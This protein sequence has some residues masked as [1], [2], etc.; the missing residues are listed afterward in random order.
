[1][2]A[3]ALPRFVAPTRGLMPHAA[4]LLLGAGSSDFFSHL[5]SLGEGSGGGSSS[6]SLLAPG[7]TTLIAGVSSSAV[8]KGVLFAA[9]I[10]IACILVEALSTGD[11][12]AGLLDDHAGHMRLKGYADAAVKE[13]GDAW[14][15]KLVTYYNS[16]VLRERQQILR[17]SHE[18]FQVAERMR[19]EQNA[20]KPSEPSKQDD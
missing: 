8:N 11:L 10:L 14:R 6:T 1:M 2:N 19:A 5:S 3:T 9:V 7:D 20:A 4:D 15:D 18:G 17:E 12:K 13:P 16:G